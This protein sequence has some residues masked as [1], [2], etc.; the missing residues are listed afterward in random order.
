MLLISLSVVA[1][2]LWNCKRK[3]NT[4]KVS[5]TNQQKIAILIVDDHQLLR[6][7]LS[8]MLADESDIVVMTG[9]SNGEAALNF[10]IQRIQDSRRLPDIILMD[11]RMPGIG[12]IEATRLILNVAPGTRI[13]AMSS[14]SFGLIPTQ[15]LNAGA[16][17]FVSKTTGI[18]E[19]LKA[20]HMVHGGS[21]YI[22]AETAVQLATDPFNSEGKA[23]FEKLSH[24][25]FQIAQMLADGYKVGEIA[26]FLHIN[27]KTVYSYRYRIFA[28][29]GVQNDVEMAVMAAEFGLADSVTATGNFAAFDRV[30]A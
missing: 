20:I 27:A 17:S 21:H 13:I 19:M 4:V 26:G 3:S 16:V 10:M 30:S 7:G 1:G 18:N 8:R 12:G 6:N 11:A 24:R 15:M 5:R 29:L 2:W 23:L 28:K 25:E 9:L 14:I 22:S